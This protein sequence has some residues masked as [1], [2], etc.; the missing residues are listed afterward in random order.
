MRLN[1][2]SYVERLI[3]QDDFEVI[4]SGCIFH[5][6][7]S[8]TVFVDIGAKVGFYTMLASGKCAVVHAFEPEPTNFARLEANAGLNRNR[9]KT[10]HFY[11]F[12]LGSELGAALL[13]ALLTDNY[14]M[15]TFSSLAKADSVE[16][17]IKRLDDVLAIIPQHYL[18]KVDVEGFELEV[19]AG[20]GGVHTRLVP[21]ST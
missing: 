17:A 14:G 5:Q 12:A 2:Y 4:R 19:L 18:F 9:G 3:S 15:A 20:C 10:I 13:N 21:G 16:V 7:H 1:K 6:M 11:N 8:D